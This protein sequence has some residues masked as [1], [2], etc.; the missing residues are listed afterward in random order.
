ME[1][2]AGGY[3]FPPERSRVGKCKYPKS[4]HALQNKGLLVL[5]ISST[6][7]S[8]HQL[9]WKR[10]L[11]TPWIGVQYKLCSTHVHA[12]FLS[13]LF[14]LSIWFLFHA[15]NLLALGGEDKC[16]TV[17]N[18]DGDTI[19]QVSTHVIKIMTKQLSLIHV[20]VQL[21]WSVLAVLRC[22]MDLLWIFLLFLFAWNTC[23]PL[24]V[25][26]LLKSSSVKWKLMNVAPL[27][28]QR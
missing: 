2:D 10:Q 5:T 25:Q 16:I 14:M 26:I 4:L 20:H 7:D 13:S 12:L 6:F 19:R 9:N 21:N 11:L 8:V 15:K 18:V 3:N 27:A 23:R 1:R 24:S 17:S 28:R 22:Y